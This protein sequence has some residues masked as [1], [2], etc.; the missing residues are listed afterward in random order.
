V[1]TLVAHCQ[2]ENLARL[3]AVKDQIGEAADE[4]SSGAL[5]KEH[6]D[7]GMLFKKRKR[8][9]DLGQELSAQAGRL[10]VIETR[11]QAEITLGGSKE[12]HGLQD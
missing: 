11:C 3:V 4:E 1:S 6:A 5:A 2:D 8:V 7:L 12:H 10:A 9:T